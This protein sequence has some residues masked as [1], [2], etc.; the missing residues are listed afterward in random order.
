MLMKRKHLLLVAFAV[1]GFTACSDDYDDSALWEQV[2]ENTDRIEALEAW[3]EQVNSNIS[4][5]QQLLST[6]DY[7]T[8]VTPVMQDGKETGYTI[9]FLHSDPITVYHGED[10]AEGHTPVIGVKEEDGVYYWTLDGE[11]LLGDDNQ[12]M[13]VTGAKG[14][15]GEDGTDGTDGRDAIAPQVRI[16][17]ESNEW[18]ISTDGGQT[19]KSTGVEATGEDGDSFFKDVEEEDD[20]VTFTLLNDDGTTTSFQVPKYQGS[21]L[22]FKVGNATPDLTQT[23]DLVDG[24][25]TYTAPQGMQVSARI[26]EG[27][28]WTAEAEGGTITISPG[29]IGEKA[30]LEV[31]LTENGRVIESY[32]LTVEQSRLRGAGMEEAPYLISTPGEL[33]Y[34]AEQVN[35]SAKNYPFFQE[36]IQLTQD[37][38]MTGIEWT[39]IGCYDG[40]DVFSPSFS[41]TFDGKNHTIKGLTISNN[42]GEGDDLAKGLFGAVNSGV[43]K[44]LTLESP[45]ITASGCHVGFIVGSLWYGTIENCKVN[46][47]SITGSGSQHVGGIT[48]NFYASGELSIRNC[49]VGADI[50][51]TATGGGT[52]GGIIGQLE[53]YEAGDLIS[54]EACS[55]SGR[56]ETSAGTT[57][58]IVGASSSYGGEV[59]IAACYSS[60]AIQSASYT[61]GIIG[62]VVKGTMVKGCYSMMNYTNE[63][64]TGGVIGSYT[65]AGASPDDVANTCYWNGTG[66]NYGFGRIS[67]AGRTDTTG[68][69]NQNVNKVDGETIQWSSAMSAMNAV[70]TGW[71]YMANAES[72]AESFPLIIQ[73]TN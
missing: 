36:Y 7:I 15:D 52:T 10:G 2:N 35:N 21:L 37:I 58:G 22:A 43:I 71:Q 32:R 34:L 3:Q 70:L 19:W 28:N 4:A 69:T 6:T 68:A 31:V 41:G 16:N 61:G 50:Y 47:G 56:I 42:T 30:L 44:N 18:E 20:Y 12:K 46:N 72:D 5:L 13:P 54:I 59:A 23:I 25:L 8:S 57:G 65:P 45:T 17:E 73:A 33:T 62:S 55:F 9:A 39:P 38:D 66:A 24:D 14:E 49:H 51:S 48:G 1:C 29:S 11:W 40:F 26:L 63:K 53:A 27:E 67:N 60:G 64:P